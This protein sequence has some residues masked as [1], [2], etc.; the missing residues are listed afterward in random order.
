MIAHDGDDWC[1]GGGLWRS[2]EG[3]VRGERALGKR[4]KMK[5]EKRQREE[6]VRVRL[7]FG[8]RRYVMGQVIRVGPILCLILQ[9]CETQSQKLNIKKNI[10]ISITQNSFF[11]VLSY[12]N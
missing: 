10:Y 8:E 7:I 3:S 5:K 12:G 9:K 11:L 2:N 1:G 6:W 4:K